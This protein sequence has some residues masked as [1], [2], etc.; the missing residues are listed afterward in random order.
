MGEYDAYQCIYPE[1]QNITWFGGPDGLFRYDASKPIMDSIPFKTLIRGVYCM[2][3]TLFGGYYGFD[4]E[5]KKIEKQ[6]SIPEVIYKKNNINFEFAALSFDNESEMFTVITLRV[7]IKAGASGPLN[8]RKV[9]P[10]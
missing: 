9:I 7:L 5:N 10:I 8:Q 4:N 3:D 1:N 2:N 6:Q